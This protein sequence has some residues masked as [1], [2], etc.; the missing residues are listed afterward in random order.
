MKT[1]IVLPAYNEEK[2]VGEVLRSCREHGFDHVIV[3]DDGSLDNTGTAAADSGAVVV[4]HMI[5]RGVGAATQT[6]L[7]AARMMGADI[8][9]TMD[10]DGQHLAGDIKPLLEILER[11]RAD[12]V[13]GSRFLNR[14]NR[15]PMLRRGFNLVANLITFMLSGIYISDSQSGMKVFSGEALARI[16]ITSNGYEFC[17]EIIREARYFR[18]R[19]SEVP[20]S[21]K[22]S[23]YTLSKGQNFA[24]GITTVFKLMLRTLMR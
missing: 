12:I 18:L 17:S 1:V 22:Y 20:I 5:N 10:A 13:I 14:K 11:D 4:S 8:A 9:V 3:V 24:S 2:Y 15:I 21:V 7:S 19:I 6:G 16:N 23:D